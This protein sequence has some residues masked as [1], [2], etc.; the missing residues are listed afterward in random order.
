[1]DVLVE[2][3][4]KSVLGS[5]TTSPTT[6][7][8][9]DEWRAELT[10]EEYEV[11][12]GKGTEP[13]GTGEY[14]D[15]HPAAGEGHF[16]C[17]ACRAPLYS[18]AAKFDSGCGWCVASSLTLATAARTNSP[19]CFPSPSPP[20]SRTQSSAADKCR[21]AFDRCYTGAIDMVLDT[22]HGLKRVEL[23]CHAC[24]GHLGHVFLGE[25]LTSNDERHC[26]NSRSVRFVKGVVPDMAEGKLSAS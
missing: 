25:K 5:A 9:E 21:P 1:M 7:K 26:V 16:A 20:L 3:L 24:G 12:R 11:I 4:E 10:P 17:R 13:A 2:S 23:T 6:S 22:S 18:A 19:V 15:F 8:T 14:A